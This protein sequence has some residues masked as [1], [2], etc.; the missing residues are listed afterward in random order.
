VATASRRGA[1]LDD[2]LALFGKYKALA[3]G[4]IAQ[5]DDAQFFEPLG[6]EENSIALV[7]KH[8]A[9]NQR[10]RWTDFLTTDGEKADR[11]RDA[12]FERESGDTRASLLDRWEE[13][14]RTLFAALEPLGEADLARVVTIRGEPHSVL[15]AVGRQLTHYAYHVGQIVLLARHHAGPRWRSLSIPRGQSAAYEVS[16]RG[17]R[18]DAPRTEPGA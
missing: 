14:W 9:G 5:V 2:A 16:K 8:L 1:F 17:E 10:S 18:Y 12:E 15:E 13:G 3:E 4:A 6:P 7:V 11:Q